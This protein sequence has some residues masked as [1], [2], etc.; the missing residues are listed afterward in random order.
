MVPFPKHRRDQRNHCDAKERQNEAALE[1]V[2]GLSAIQD[3]F[4]ECEAQRHE[5][6]SQPINLQPSVGVRRLHLAGKL[7]WIENYAAGQD[8]GNDADR[9]IDEKDPAPAPIIGDPT[10]ERRP[11]YRR[12]DDGH[13]VK[14]KCG[15]PLLRGKGVDKN[16][17]LHRSQPATTHTLQ[18][19]EQDQHSQAWRQAAEQRTDGK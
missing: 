10:S 4:H 2:F 6:N 8:Q 14:R 9:N 16:G 1:P 7:R 3:H 11:D 15:S 19:P 13:A 5:E 12:G 18:H 17:L